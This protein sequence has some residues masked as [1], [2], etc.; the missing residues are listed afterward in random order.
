MMKKKIPEK[1]IAKVEIVENL[2]DVYQDKTT[3]DETHHKKID[4]IWYN[5]RPIIGMQHF[6]SVTK[7]SMPILGFLIGIL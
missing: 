1:K 4:S 3:F 6:L 5:L 7:E 2:I